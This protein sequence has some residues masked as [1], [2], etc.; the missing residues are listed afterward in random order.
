MR[1]LLSYDFDFIDDSSIAFQTEMAVFAFLVQII[2]SLFTRRQ[3]KLSC[4]YAHTHPSKNIK[5]SRKTSNYRRHGYSSIDANEKKLF[6]YERRFGSVLPKRFSS[7]PL[8]RCVFFSVMAIEDSNRPESFRFFE[9]I[10]CTVGLAHSTGIMQQK[11]NK[12]LS[13]H[14]SVKL[15]AAYIS[16]MW[17]TFLTT[18]AKSIQSGY[19]PD[20]IVFTSSWY[21]YDYN[22]LADATEN[23][24]GY[25]YGDYCGT[26]LLD[27]GV[28]FS[29]VKGFWER[30]RYGLLP[31]TVISSWDVP[32]TEATWFGSE[33]IYWMN[34]YTVTRTTCPKNLD[35]YKLIVIDGGSNQAS[36]EKV[37]EL[38]RRIE[39]RMGFVIKV[40]LIENVHVAIYAYCA[41]EQ[42][43]SIIDNEWRI[44]R[45]DEGQSKTLFIED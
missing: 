36:Y 18:F 23:A 3:Y 9:R 31:Q 39:S 17:D 41:A 43:D 6:E 20:A 11:S 10:A 13:D 32:P 8:L 34:D 28:V 5:V 16:R 30:N 40:T 44:I 33:K 37:A 14:E 38:H 25:F 15:A 26:R 27:A 7:D 4:R 29:Q 22:R 42:V 12:P 45:I 24:F 21:K 35:G 2:T 19:S 1:R